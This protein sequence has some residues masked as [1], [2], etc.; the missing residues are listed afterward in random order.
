MS[1]PATTFA[2]NQTVTANPTLTFA[3]S[4]V[5]INTGD[6]VTWNNVGG[7]H[8][9]NFDD[10]SYTMPPAPAAAPWTVTRTFTAPGM[11][12]YYCQLHGG[13]NGSGMSGI[14]WVFGPGYARPRG[15]T[16]MRVSL[17]PAYQPCTTPNSTHGAPLSHPSCNPPT[18]VSN[19]VTVG[20]PDSN[21]APA[22]SIG[23]VTASVLSPADVRLV[24]S[25]TD[26]RKK[27]DLSPYTGQLQATIPLRITDHTNGPSLSDPATGDT[28]V[29]FAIPC[30]GGSPTVGSTCSITTTANA[31]VPGAVVGGSR[32]NWEIKNV[33]VFDGGSSGT[34]GAPDATL[35]AD[36]AIFE[37]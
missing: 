22:A 30:S 28:S 2:A 34:A 4:S 13:P 20:T 23:S 21:G 16:P 33:Q 3:P 8:N 14:V 10:G 25:I 1:G 26:V 31:V 37:P 17:A 9:V 24:A 7:T 32:A 19:F 12:R 36:Q 35:F 27:S 6:T 29:S 18:Q 11:F 5:T 15:A